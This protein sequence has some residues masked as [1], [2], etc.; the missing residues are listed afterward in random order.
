MAEYSF[1]WNV[2]GFPAG[3]VPVTRV[4]ESEQTFTDDWKDK[5]TELLNSNCSGSEDMPICVQVVGYS[6]Q[7]EHVLAIMKALEDKIQFDV[8]VPEVDLRPLEQQKGSGLQAYRG[9]HSLRLPSAVGGLRMS[10]LNMSKVDATIETK[11]LVDN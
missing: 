3:I 10:K 2:T 8:N 11:Q 5:Y 1:I 7:D 6:F 4:L 9:A